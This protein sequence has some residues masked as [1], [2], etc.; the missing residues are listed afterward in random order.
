MM[1]SAVA[2]A[3][4]LVAGLTL[5]PSPYAEPDAAA[6]VVDRTVV[7]T[8]G[9]ANG[10]KVI[11]VSGRSGF[12]KGDTFEW[13]SYVD[14]ST[15][16]SPLPRKRNQ[17]RPS[18]SAIVAGWPPKPPITANGYGF[19]ADKHCR[20]TRIR[21][22]FT[23]TRLTGG[24]ASQF[25]EERTC[26]PPGRILIRL[27]GEFTEPVELTLLGTK[28]TRRYQAVGHMVRAQIAVRNA[29]GK[30]LVYGEATASGRTKLFTARSC[31]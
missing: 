29:A 7:C 21:V 13:P 27:R 12:K 2:L 1:R 20:L 25:G 15:G 28:P 10:A 23:K 11:Y 14:V 16:G 30:P 5:S 22:P 31:S 4:A 6:P 24:V 17:Y 19:D 8:T 18:L 3:L 9:Y 26:V